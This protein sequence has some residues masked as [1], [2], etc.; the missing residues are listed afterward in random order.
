M[1]AAVFE[2]DA[3]RSNPLDLAEQLILD[4]EWL[5]D[6]PVEEELVA[7]VQ[8]SWCNYRIW[9]TWQPDLGV[10]IF[11][12]AYDVKIHEKHRS[13]LFPLLAAVNEKL[14]LGHFDLSGDDGVIMYRHAQLFRGAQGCAPEQLEDLLDIAIT[15]CNRF[16]PAF[17]SVLWGGNTHEEALEIA[18]LDTV[19][20][21]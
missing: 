1:T 15:E 2:T 13:K 7:E 9:F 20:E 12:C 5:C 11:S 19:G 18:L 14:W 3:L 4:R 10:L 21:A 8:S 17:Q 6:R 16:F